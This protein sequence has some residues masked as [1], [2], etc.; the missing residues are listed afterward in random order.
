MGA[1]PGIFGTA[2]AQ[3]YLRQMFVFLNLHPINRPEV[4]IGNAQDQLQ[5][6]T[7]SLAGG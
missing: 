5:V 4:M 3:Y 1:S 6:P 2:R 7:P